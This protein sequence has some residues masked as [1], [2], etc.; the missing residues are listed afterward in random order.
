MVDAGADAAGTSAACAEGEA[1]AAGRVVA[2]VASAAAVASMG[3]VDVVVAPPLPS[4]P[5]GCAYSSLFQRAALSAPLMLT[6]SCVEGK[7]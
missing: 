6:S 7:R 1:A 3:S 2:V 5:S 4:P